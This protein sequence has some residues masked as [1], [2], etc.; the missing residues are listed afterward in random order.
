MMS[1][2]S[3]SSP[4]DDDLSAAKPTFMLRI[5][6][7]ALWFLVSS[8]L[9][10]L[11][12]LVT[13]IVP[14]FDDLTG[15]LGAI[16]F[17]PV[18]TIFPCLFILAAHHGCYHGKRNMANKRVNLK[19]IEYIMCIVIIT[20]GV[21]MIVLGFIANVLSAVEKSGKFGQPF[22]CHCRAEK[23]CIGH[24][25]HMGQ[26]QGSANVSSYIATEMLCA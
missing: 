22:D 16:A 24:D 6:A 18:A 21:V 14:F 5:V 1:S 8:T 25:A 2:T 7:F 13:N 12:F 11:A 9:C 19:P 17:T 3:L 15:I 4:S 20:F 23:C 10:F 26:Q